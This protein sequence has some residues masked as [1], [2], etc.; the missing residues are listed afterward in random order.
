MSACGT[1]SCPG[2]PMAGLRIATICLC[3]SASAAWS[4]ETPGPLAEWTFDEGKGE[5]ARDSSGNERHAAVSGATRVK[6]G[7]GFALSLDGVDDYVA[8]ADGPPLDLT[9]PVTVEAWVKPT[10]KSP[11][12]AVI[13]GQDLHSYLLCLS[14]GNRCFWYIGAG[15]NY[16]SAQIRLNA[17][18]H[19]AATFGQE[20]MALWVN[21]QPAA[22]RESQFE[23]Y[24]KR[25]RFNMG[26]KGRPDLPKFKGLLDNVRVY[27]RALP[28]QEVIQHMKDEAAQYDSSLVPETA[29]LS[30]E[31]TAFFKTHPNPIDLEE[32]DGSILFAN[33][34]TGIELGVGRQGFHLNRLY[35]IA[36]EQDYL[37][38]P[39]S[40]RDL[41]D[42][43]LAL[44]PRRVDKDE[45]HLTKR[46]LMG[47]VDEMAADAFSV[48]SREAKSVAWRHEGD[49][50]ESRLYL[51]WKGMSAR[52]DAEVLDVE[53]TIT[54]K[55]GDA[56]S[57][58]RI[59]VRNRGANY[60][61]E[62]LV[63][64]I[65]NL[66]PIGNA[67][68]DV[69]IYPQ[70]RGRMVKNP[71]KGL[72]VRGYYTCEFEMQFQALYNGRSGNGIYLATQQTVP[73]FSHLEIAC[74]P[75]EIAWRPAH[76]PPNVTFAQEYI[77]SGGDDA[78]FT[79]SYD[80]VAGPFRGDW[81]DA[82]QIYRAWALQ[83][84]WC[85]KGPVSQRQDIPAWY[86][87][88]PFYFYVSL[89]DSATGTNSLDE[90]LR[91]AAD[92]LREWLGWTGMK[93]PAN[94]YSWE[95]PVHGLSTRDLPT[96]VARSRYRGKKG[97][98]AGMTGHNFYDGNYPGIEALAEF[99]DICGSLR[100]QGGMVC[101]YI[102]L[103]IFNQGPAENA[104]YAAGARPGA[105]RDLFGAIRTWGGERAW[106]MCS[107]DPWWR[108]RLK[109][110]C[111]LM[112]DNENVGGFYLDVM[113]GSCLPC[114][115][116]AHGH[117][118][119]G[120]DS[121][122]A[123]R[124]ELVR[125]LREAIRANDPE[126][127]MTGENPSENMIDVIDGMLVYTLWPDHVPL[128]ATVY[129]D[130]MLRYGLEL[131]VDP[132]GDAFFIDCASLFTAGAQVGRLRLKPRSAMVSLREPGHQPMIDFLEQVLGY[133]KQEQTQRFLSLG[134][135]MRP[136]TFD[137][138]APMPVLAH[139]NGGRFPALWS[140]VFRDVD[141]ELGVFIVNASSEPV[142]FEAAMD[143]ARHG[144]AAGVMVD[145]TAIAP[146]G[147]ATPFQNEAAGTATLRGTLPG[148]RITMFRIRPHGP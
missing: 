112:L 128:F 133:Y 100:E 80:C 138:P 62:R 46:S 120:A 85:A 66:A 43:R 32:R 124:H 30:S 13:L 3:V 119:A 7:D 52:G 55:A 111:E 76:F 6:Q 47:I 8:F 114:Y 70:S 104:P 101:P 81:Y 25:D 139:P 38:A 79:L 2:L 74:T 89:N 103:E 69:L 146:D 67:A 137:K 130:Y 17:W 107:W 24:D 83:Q 108:S 123:G 105:I 48:G 96:H 49:A 44:D 36:E 126:A 65:L 72:T 64:P 142:A 82:C 121:M 141:G 84:S 135:L 54:L 129:Q 90:N 132:D 18:N 58:W 98:W 35:G 118:A 88:A 77:N 93:L 109:E 68:D 144:M 115:W 45:S 78:E 37:V 15:S 60:G 1:R 116:I 125:I 131:S 140:G 92:H 29:T 113:R 28:G 86:K 11:A 27:D 9:G 73:C 91:I 99:S 59:A 41:F 4:A 110:T 143:L 145:V 75:N 5:I 71:F 117:T 61:I 122:T 97:R 148:R 23:R 53:V 20:G 136:L 87:Q 10:R 42:I 57:Y 134:Q 40:S 21:A 51:E 12:L 56:L 16:V 94:F 102:A 147:A 33:R 26:T 63:F 14:A 95:Q 22:A 106:Q 34:Q 127:I 31:A 50:S 19:I 39:E